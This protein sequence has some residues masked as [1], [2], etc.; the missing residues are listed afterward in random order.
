[1]QNSPSEKSVR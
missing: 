1:M